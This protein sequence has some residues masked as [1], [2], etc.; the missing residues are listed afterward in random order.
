MTTT[1]HTWFYTKPENN[2]YALAERVR[3]TLWD[4]RIGNIWLDTVRGLNRLT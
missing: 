2:A 4:A 3:T 1:A